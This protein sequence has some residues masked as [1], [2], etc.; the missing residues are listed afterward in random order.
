M[1]L[2]VEWDTLNIL[3]DRIKSISKNYAYIQHDKDLEEDKTPK[4]VHIHCVVEMSAKRTINGLYDMLAD[5]CVGFTSNLIII[6]GNVNSQIRY[7]THIDYPEKYPYEYNDI[8]T[9]N[10]QWL[11]ELYEIE[12]DDLTAYKII[13]TFIN[14][15]NKN[16]SLSEIGTLCIEKNCFKFY[17]AKTYL[18]KQLLFEHNKMFDTNNLIQSKVDR[19]TIKAIGRIQ[20]ENSV[21]TKLANTFDRVNVENDNGDIIEIMN[22]GKK[23]KQ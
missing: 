7:L 20:K 12:T 15:T 4:K 23:R 17:K 1:L 8:K 3:I 10:Q 6:P 2:Y 22:T 18:I 19:E 14:E 9:N 11:K 5:T 13:D 21:I 16:I